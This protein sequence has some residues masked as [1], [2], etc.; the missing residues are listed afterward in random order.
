MIL[1][2]AEKNITLCTDYACY[3]FPFFHTHMLGY[4][5]EEA[6]LHARTFTATLLQLHITKG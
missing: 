3:A 4:V 6:S 5:S 2:Q 1:M